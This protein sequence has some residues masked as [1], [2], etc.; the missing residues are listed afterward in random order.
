MTVLS[1]LSTFVFFDF[2]YFYLGFGMGSKIEGAQLKAWD[3][4]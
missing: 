2:H 4:I 3:K 1:A